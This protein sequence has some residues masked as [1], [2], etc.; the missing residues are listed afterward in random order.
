MTNSHP[1]SWLPEDKERRVFI[2]LFI[3][4]MALMLVMSE[5]GEALINET[6]SS[7]IISFELAGDLESAQRMLDSWDHQAQIRAGLSL[8]LDYL[9]LVAY[10]AAISLGCVL[11]AR[12]LDLKASSLGRVGYILAWLLPVAALLDAIEN[13]ALIRL[14]FGSEQA[15]WP[16]I[17]RWTAIPK[18]VIVILGLVYFLLGLIVVIFL[19][20]RGSS[21]QSVV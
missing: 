9:Y 7:G 5:I 19:R 8:G 3:F 6:A 11:V 2:V 16:S 12:S 17:A 21:R 15:Y 18:F 20:Y 4:T 10:A 14:L 13:Y 1:L